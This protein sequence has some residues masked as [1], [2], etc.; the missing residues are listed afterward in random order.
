M[1]FV[2]TVIKGNRYF[3]SDSP[4]GN[5]VLLSDST[6]MVISGRAT[7]GSDNDGYRFEARR[8]NETYI[9]SD[10]VGKPTAAALS[11]LF[12][13]LAQQMGAIVVSGNLSASSPAAA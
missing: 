5:R 2:V 6:D 10:F 8:A 11:A 7:G 3:E 1:W 12:M 4:I 9:V 13:S